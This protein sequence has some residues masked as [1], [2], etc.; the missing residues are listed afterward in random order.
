MKR[1]PSGRNNHQTVYHDKKLII[2]G[3]LDEFQ[4]YKSNPDL[5]IYDTSKDPR[6]LL[7]LYLFKGLH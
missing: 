3:G 5:L 2:V 6:K 4:V 7:L 1:G